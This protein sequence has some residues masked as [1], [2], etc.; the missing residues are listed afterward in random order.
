MSP[1]DFLQFKSVKTHKIFGKFSSTNETRYTKWNVVSNMFTFSYQ[2]VALFYIHLGIFLILGNNAFSFRR[3]YLQER[4]G[5]G[6]GRLPRRERGHRLRDR[7]RPARHELPLEVQQLRRNSRRGRR[8]FRQNQQRQRQR[9]ALHTRL[10]T[11]LRLALLLGH[12]LR[13]PPGQSVRVPGRRSRSVWLDFLNIINS[14][15][16]TLETMPSI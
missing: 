14:L 8:T 11:R 5:D 12:Q 9:A 6:G 10:R 3:S 16:V 7:V 4:E 13:G 2:F 1:C 15:S